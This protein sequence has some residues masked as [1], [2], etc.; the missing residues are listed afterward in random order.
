M[1]LRRHFF[2]LQFADSLFQETHVGIE[3][4][5]VDVAMLLAPQQIPGAAKLQI[6]RGDLEA[7]SQVAELLQRRQALARDFAELGIGRH[8]QV[9]VSAAVGAA[10]AAAKLIQFRKALPFRIFDNNGICKGNVQA[11]FYYGST[12]Q[13]IELMPHEPQHG[14]LQFGLAHLAV[15]HANPGTWREFLN[16]G[17]A[18]PNGIHLIMQEIDLPAAA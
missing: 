13:N 17:G 8:Q 6:Q 3:A 4:D 7:G 12:Y 15:A 9:G 11:V 1:D 14:L 2:A 18:L 5:G 10:H 16:H